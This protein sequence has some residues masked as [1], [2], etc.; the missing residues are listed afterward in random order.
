MTHKLKILPEYYNAV[1]SGSKMFEIRENDRNFNIGDI[2]NL[3]EFD[4]EK[5]TERELKVKV[6]YILYGGYGLDRNWCC[7]SIEKL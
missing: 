3:M 7:M 4:G 6:T 5:Y 1:L 2:L